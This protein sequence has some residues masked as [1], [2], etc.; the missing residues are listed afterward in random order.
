[1]NA[2]L[3]KSDHSFVWKYGQ[4]LMPLLDPK[5]GEWILDAGCGTGELTAA[6]A[7]TG[8]RVTGIDLSADMIGKARAQFPHLDLAVSGIVEYQPSREFDA[9]FSNAVLHWI[10]DAEG[11]VRMIARALRVGGRFVAEFGGA[12]NCRSI[13]G[14]TGVN[15][16]YFPTVGEYAPILERNGLE[17]RR[18]ELFDRWTKLE[19][20]ENAIE[21]WVRMFGKGMPQDDVSLRALRE[22]LRPLLYRDGSWWMDYRRLRVVAVKL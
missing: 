18:A 22:K 2:E 7:E 16:W 12:G 3:Y 17:V 8:A 11:A 19:D 6:I 5:P 15:P 1:M 21:D 14:A 10:H 9:V 4:E 20:P 13:I